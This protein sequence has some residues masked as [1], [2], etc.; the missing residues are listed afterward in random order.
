MPGR[1]LKIVYSSSDQRLELAAL[2]NT[3]DE[4]LQTIG[5]LNGR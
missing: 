4:Q 1:V 5:K 3:L 2:R